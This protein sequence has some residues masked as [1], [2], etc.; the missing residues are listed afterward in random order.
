MLLQSKQP[1]GQV[2]ISYSEERK[3]EMQKEGADSCSVLA[4]VLKHEIENAG[5]EVIKITIPE[6]KDRFADIIIEFKT[7]DD[8]VIKRI[9]SALDTIREK[10]RGIEES[11]IF[12]TKS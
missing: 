3:K 7:S 2:L 11:T 6:K 8:D 1:N 12:R 5:A 10:R 4:K 9:R